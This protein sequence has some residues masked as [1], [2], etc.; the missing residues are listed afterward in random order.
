LPAYAGFS[1]S[2]YAGHQV[3][4]GDLLFQALPGNNGEALLL[5]L[6]E[7]ARWDNRSRG[8]MDWNVSVHKLIVGDFNGDGRNDLFAT[9]Q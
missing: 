3:I 7:M 4:A 9:G 1:S 8:R 2:S 6:E 5:S